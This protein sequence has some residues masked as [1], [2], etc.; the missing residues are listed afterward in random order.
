MA[1]SSRKRA[2]SQ[3][4]LGRPGPVPTINTTIDHGYMHTQSYRPV[5]LPIPG[6]DQIAP[7]GPTPILPA[8]FNDLDSFSTCYPF[9]V[10]DASDGSY[11]PYSLTPYGMDKSPSL[12]VRGFSFY[13]PGIMGAPSVSVSPPSSASTV[14]RKSSTRSTLSSVNTTDFPQQ[15]DC[16]QNPSWS[17][18]PSPLQ[19]I[20]R[21]VRSPSQESTG[22]VKAS[23]GHYSCFAPPQRGES[24]LP[25]ERD[26]EPRSQLTQVPV[27]NAHICLW[28]NNGPCDSGGFAT[29]EELA[30]HVKSEHLMLCPVVGCTESLFPT[31]DLLDCHVRWA[32]KDI[33]SEEEEKRECQ[34]SNLLNEVAMKET[35]T[36]GN[37]EVTTSKAPDVKADQWLKME[38]SIG[39]SK[40]RC[41]E[42][43]KNVIDKKYRKN[44]GEFSLVPPNH[45]HW[46]IY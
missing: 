4:A 18:G 38:M 25:Q 42:Q 3:A 34:S 6:P 16:F 1:S 10:R 21:T 41:R 17:R 13:G 31:K 19:S 44:S 2:A 39:I 46:I 23:D 28:G 30:W 22:T 11:G 37:L 24:K 45:H 14:S 12:E 26:R 7:V 35:A 9:K 36:V 20:V 27:S 15:S 40:K 5:S 32:H 43:L 29:R 8:Q 33:G